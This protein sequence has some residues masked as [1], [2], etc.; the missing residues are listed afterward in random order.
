MRRWRR[1]EQDNDSGQDSFLDIVANLVGILIIL[2]MV[3]GVRAKDA[4]VEAAVSIRPE[5]DQLDVNVETSRKMA[6]RVQTDIYSLQDKL[7]DVRDEARLQITARHRLATLITAVKHDLDT[8]RQQLDK[9]SRHQHDL[10]RSILASQ[11]ELE[12]L[13][14]SQRIIEQQA[15]ETVPL[16][17]HPT[18]MAKTVFGR[19][20][21]YRLLSGRVAYV[22][23]N[24]FVEQLSAEWQQ[25][26][27]KLKDS[28][29]VTEVLGPIRG[30][31]MKY[32]IAK[33]AHLVETSIGQQNRQIVHVSGFVLIPIHEDLGAPLDEALAEGSPFQKTLAY[34]DPRRTTV[35]IWTY[36]DS[37]AEFRLLKETLHQL[38]FLT[39]G[40]PIPAGYPIGGSPSGTRSA[41]Q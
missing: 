25:K 15:E 26:V 19:E 24:E 30:F 1:N 11:R 34:H 33:S 40:R 28:P 10:Q 13:A 3:I 4:L 17:H 20:L 35:T 8:Q 23:I 37:F 38:G 9:S 41:A 14:H 6:E 31:H 21:H 12:D 27:W 18:P 36:P 2:V 16:E 39:A 22:P 5:S 7:E 32:G 29:E